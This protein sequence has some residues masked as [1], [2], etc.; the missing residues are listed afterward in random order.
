LVYPTGDRSFWRNLGYGW[1]LSYF[2]KGQ[3]LLLPIPNPV[4]IRV[5]I[6][7]SII[8]GTPAVVVGGGV[9][10]VGIVV[11]CVVGS[12]VRLGVCVGVDA[13]SEKDD[14][15]TAFGTVTPVTVTR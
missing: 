13:T 14:V 1:A 7:M 8:T 6:P 10:S 9:G 3:P 15:A 12:V 2:K 4:R 5:T 11:C